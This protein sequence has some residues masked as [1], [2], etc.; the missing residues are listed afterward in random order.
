MLETLL[1]NYLGTYTLVLGNGAALQN[2]TLNYTAGTLRFDSAVSSNEFT[3]GGLTGTASIGLTNTSGG[4]ITLSLG[5]NN[6]TT[7]YTGALSDAGTGGALKKI[8]TGT[9][10]LGGANSYSGATTVS[11]GS[12]MTRPRMR[13]I[14][15]T[16]TGSMPIARSASTSSFSFIAPISAAKAL[17]E[18]P[19]M[20]MAVSSTPSSRSTETVTRSTTKMLA[21]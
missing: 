12:A 3:F 19:A 21:P 2:S 17:P 6:S 8:G 1:L 16:S 15:R 9:L 13:G 20:M 7:T 10:T 18:R 11:A 5:N 4:A 14:T